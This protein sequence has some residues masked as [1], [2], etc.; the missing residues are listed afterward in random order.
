M[1]KNSSILIMEIPN[2][3]VS[4][5]SMMNVFD[6]SIT[7]VT[8]S[9]NLNSLKTNNQTDDDIDLMSKMSVKEYMDSV[10][11]SA[12]KEDI[13]NLSFTERIRRFLRSNYVHVAVI[14]LVLLDS[15][16][17]T[18]EL[19]LDLEDKSHHLN[20]VED[21]FKYLGFSILCI[22]FVEISL[23]ILFLFKEFI[24]SKLEIFDAIVVM[25][26]FAIE[27]VFMKNHGALAAIGIFSNFK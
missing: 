12:L 18:V 3:R 5:Q 7:V 25:V 19:I 21:T 11:G 15:F 9:N 23:K 17:V 10:F 6:D 20:V 16:C 4:S 24:K 13:A 14:I 1:R 27:I 2:S 22:F 26:S 8:D